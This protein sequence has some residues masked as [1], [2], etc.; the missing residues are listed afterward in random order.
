MYIFN[1]TVQYM[2]NKHTP[3]YTSIGY[4]NHSVKGNLY[5]LCIYH[6]VTG[7]PGESMISLSCIKGVMY[8]PGVSY[9]NITHF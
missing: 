4:G 2:T 7:K 3:L 6:D 8:R 9:R 5:E 1:A